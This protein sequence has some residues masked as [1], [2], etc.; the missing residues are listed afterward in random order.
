MPASMLSPPSFVATAKRVRKA[1]ASMRVVVDLP[2]VPVTRT[3]GRP[4]ASSPMMCGSMAPAMRP[5]IMP[6]APRPVA[7]EAYVAALAAVFATAVR[8]FP[9]TPI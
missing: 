6:P 3:D 4:P 9:R 1:A 2:F 5:P 7:R 8:A